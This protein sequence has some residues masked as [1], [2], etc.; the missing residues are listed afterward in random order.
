MLPQGFEQL[1]SGP[2]HARQEPPLTII[3]R[4]DGKSRVKRVENRQELANHA[5]SGAI[6]C[7]R[8]FAQSPL[9]KVVEIGG[10]PFQIVE[11]RGRLVPR[12]GEVS[13]ELLDGLV[14]VLGEI[15]PGR[16]RLDD[17]PDDDFRL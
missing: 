3:H 14:S 7:H 5:F 13:K 1:L 17:L 4:L 12:L 6:E 16:G 9:S 10:D 15:E 2:D 11:I 8:L